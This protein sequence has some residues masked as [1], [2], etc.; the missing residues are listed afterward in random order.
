MSANG[1]PCGA[2]GRAV[3][4][5]R[6]WRIAARSDVVIKTDGAGWFVDDYAGHIAQALRGRLRVGIVD[7]LA[8]WLRR[9]VVHV[10]DG[11]CFFGARWMESTRPSH[12]V[13]GTWWHGGPDS[14]AP[15]LREAAARLE[16]VGR[17]LARV[18]VTCEM[19]RDV[20]RK[21]G[22]PE[23]KSV[24]LPFGVDATRFYPPT[25][26]QREEAR[27]RLGI[28]SGAKVVGL[29]QKD[30]DGWAEGLDPKLVKGPDIFVAVMARLAQRHPVYALVPGPA[31][32]FVLR[33]LAGA[34]IPHRNDGH[35]PVADLARYYHACDL[36]IVPGRE[37]GG[38]A[39]VLES[40]ATAT[41]LVS[42]R[43]GMAPDL[44]D[45]GR[46]GYLADVGDVEMLAEKADRVLRDEAIR[47][48]FRTEGV[49]TARA[50]FWP[51]MASRYEALYTSVLRARHPAS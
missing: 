26:A 24:L 15:G 12:H 36:Y 18:Q 9:R 17:R 1:A 44:I 7:Q 20:V 31:R 23:E 51:A 3:L 22:V 39:A 38:P 42:H 13:I 32:G 34:G 45:D 35:V 46:N 10:A 29:F 37:E 11:G 49:R 25:D 48:R 30:G 33:G 27:R 28:P 41:P 16:P 47:E 14:I 6:A 8:P 2:I 5:I 21:A 50:F 4:A 40:L 43:V 19:S